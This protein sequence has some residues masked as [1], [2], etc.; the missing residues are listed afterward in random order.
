MKQYL[1]GFLHLVENFLTGHGSNMETRF[2][3]I[4]NNVMCKEQAKLSCFASVRERDK[5]VKELGYLQPH[6]IFHFKIEF[7][8]KMLQWYSI[9]IL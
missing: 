1:D 4:C 8:V 2:Y 3:I 9:S 7:R 6:S 5:R